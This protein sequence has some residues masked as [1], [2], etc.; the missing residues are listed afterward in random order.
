MW[1]PLLITLISGLRA[2]APAD[3]PAD[4]KPCTPDRSPYGPGFVVAVELAQG[5]TLGRGDPAPYAGS[6]R[7]YP[8]FILDRRRQLRAAAV[9]GLALVNPELEALIGGRASKSVFELNAG[10]IRGVG[11][12]LGVEALYGTTDRVLLGAALIL[13]AGGAF[14]ATLRADQDVTNDA[15]VLEVG[16]GINVHTGPTPVE[17]PRRPQTPTTYPGRVAQL[18]ARAVKAAIGEVKNDPGCTELISAARTFARKRSPTVTTEADFRRALYDAS[19]SRIERQLLPLPE[20]P[21][22]ISETDVVAALYR[23][24]LDGIET[25]GGP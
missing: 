15:T 3:S 16:V 8:T 4:D 6:A 24:M 1:T 12:H 14:Q 23:G 13:D 21:V 9:A 11:A 22:E 20:R 10:P 2:I 7:L 17:I 18:A 5:V 19:L 25:P